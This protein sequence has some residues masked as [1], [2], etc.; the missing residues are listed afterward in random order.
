[1][2]GRGGPQEVDSTLH[3]EGSAPTAHCTLFTQCTKHTPHTAHCTPDGR[4]CP[5][6]TPMSRYLKLRPPSFVPNREEVV[7]DIRKTLSGAILDP[8]DKIE[9]PPAG[10]LH[11]SSSLSRTSSM[12]TTSCP[13]CWR[14]TGPTPAPSRQR[15][16]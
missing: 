6:Q 11:Q 2:A 7:N 12:I 16:G 14:R 3:P 4:H 15:S 1:M 9:V 5:P 10:S 8:E 13:S